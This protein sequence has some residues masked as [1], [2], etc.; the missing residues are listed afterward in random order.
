MTE[1]KTTEAVP[2]TAH[3]TL[4][5]ALVAA[6]SEF[7]EIP[8]DG[9]GKVS[10]TNKDG[11]YYEFDYTYATLPVIFRLTFPVLHRHGLALTQTSGGGCLITTLLHTSGDK[12]ESSLE[13]PS[14]RQLSPQKFGAA[15]SYYRRYEANGM[16]GLAPDDDIDAQGVE[17]PQDQPTASTTP[18]A[19]PIEEAAKRV[20]YGHKDLV[21]TWSLEPLKTEGAALRA[22]R[23]L[24]E[25][26]AAELMPEGW[27]PDVDLYKATVQKMNGV[28]DERNAEE[29]P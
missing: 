26:V 22:V 19:G 3:K 6:Q 20:V 11:K 17:A 10:G 4:A 23:D 16:L 1:K 24:V 29:G 9:I 2:T 8:K 15:H 27:D 18:P 13:M 21:K 5:E 7:P 14:P 25:V 12:L 28:I